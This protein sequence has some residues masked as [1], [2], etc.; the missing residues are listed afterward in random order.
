MSALRHTKLLAAW[1]ACW[2]LASLAVAQVEH[3]PPCCEHDFQWFEPVALDLDCQPDT[4]DCG[5]FFHYDKLYWAIG[6]EQSLLGD[7]NMYQDII[8]PYVL[9]QTGNGT[10]VIPDPDD[11]AGDPTIGPQAG[12]EVIINVAMVGPSIRDAG[13]RAEFGWGDRYE[14]GFGDRE[15]GWMMGILDGPDQTQSFT[16]GDY[17][18]VE[19]TLAGGGLGV[20]SIY[21]GAP[22]VLINPLGGVFIPFQDSEGRMFGWLDLLEQSNLQGQGTAEGPV[23]NG[24]I[25]GDG[26]A[27]DLDHDF[28]YGPD[29]FD[30][31]EPGGE[32]DVVATLPP[33]FDDLYH[34]PT[35]AQF[36]DIRSHTQLDGIEIQRFHNLRNDHHM[37]KHQNNQLRLMYGV[38]YMRLRDQ[39]D[40]ST[41]G[42]TL[43]NS[44]WYTQIDNN[45]VG[46]QIGLSWFHQKQKFRFELNSRFMAA[47]NIGDW[48][49]DGGLFTAATGGT[50]YNKPLNAN[51]FFF[52]H[53][54]Q[55]E[56]FSPLAELRAQLSYQVTT[57]I[58]ARLGYTG[59]YIGNIHRSSTSIRY[60]LDGMGF[61]E[62]TAENI[63][64]NGLNFG[65]DVVY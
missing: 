7:S 25:G 62:G 23:A 36:V 31:E 19:E 63:F 56:G 32:P 61:K 8:T 6:G 29:G 13:P 50:T 39:Y 3:C 58:S 54:Q 44:F 43:M 57:A 53:S 9:Q 45:L 2:S 22:N 34:L 46:P 14:L 24:V 5:L 1:A 20:P 60:S 52:A 35:T 59:T 27:D 30:T 64:I 11:P 49:Q 51:P 26:T 47:Y 55:T 16:F 42:G 33:D 4:P 65:V 40:V 28:Q 10:I 48:N 21:P 17:T 38:R 37:A 15:G 12:E 18:G 41:F